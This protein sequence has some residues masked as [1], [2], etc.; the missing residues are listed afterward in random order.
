MESVKKATRV[1]VMKLIETQ[2]T[3]SMAPTLGTKVSVISCTE[4]SACRRPM[5][6]PATSATPR[7]GEEISTATQSPCRRAS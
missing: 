7:S 5:V 3:S 2:K 4:V 6:T 1:V